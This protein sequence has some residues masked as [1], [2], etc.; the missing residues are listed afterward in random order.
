M[1]I[2]PVAAVALALPLLAF[3]LA[4]AGPQ[5]KK[6]APAA[7]TYQVDAVHSN[8]SFK[9]MH[10]KL[11]W[12]YGRFNEFTG[13]FT[14]DPAKPE[15]SM[16]DVTIDVATID[17]KNTKRDDHLRSPDFFDVKQ[18]PSA[19]FKSKSVAGK[20]DN[21]Y[22]VTGDLTLHGV[23]KPVTIHIEHTGSADGEKGGKLAGFFG[24]VK[25]KRSDFGIKFM[26]DAL[27]DEVEITLSIEGMS[28]PGK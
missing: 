2:R 17:T 10:K 12:A 20:G 9:I 15:S 13:S 3:A 27:G 26:P 23:T 11:A 8:V 1:K 25:V 22:A 7:G 16:V 21:T 5:D 19:T 14:L 18:F 28:G 4:S 6:P 24:T